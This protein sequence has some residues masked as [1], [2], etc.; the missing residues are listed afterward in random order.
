MHF[1][2]NDQNI[3]W[4]TE[5]NQ[6]ISYAKTLSKT[7][8]LPR[9]NV[10][11]AT[12][13]SIVSEQ[14]LSKF[15]SQLTGNDLSSGT[16]KLTCMLAD[17]FV[18]D[19]K[20]GAYLVSTKEARGIRYVDLW[21]N[22]VLDIFGDTAYHIDNSTQLENYR[23]Q[24]LQNVPFVVLITY[25]VHITRELV[26][27]LL[28]PSGA[29][30]RPVLPIFVG[31]QTVHSN[32]SDIVE[33]I[34]LPYAVIADM[35][36]TSDDKEIKKSITAKLSSCKSLYFHNILQRL[37][38]NR[39]SEDR[40]YRYKMRRN[41]TFVEL[42]KLIDVLRARVDYNHALVRGKVTTKYGLDAAD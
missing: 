36:G 28:Y 12:T 42:Y 38:L 32:V 6:F 33:I 7:A 18:N 22:F 30:N 15:M 13:D 25:P 40:E 8:N 37:S 5:K 29:H 19:R 3:R 4:S 17:V 26:D 27:D 1:E 34:D 31:N 41:D 16:D 10:D 11:Y 24:C 2:C 14:Y 9:L 35:V 39:P 21:V 20:P 23:K